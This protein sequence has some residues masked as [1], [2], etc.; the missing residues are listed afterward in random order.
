MNFAS[1]P[2]L[3]PTP[4]APS[5]CPFHA[6]PETLDG[7]LATQT[8]VRAVLASLPTDPSIPLPPGTPTRAELTAQLAAIATGICALTA[9]PAA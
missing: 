8:K 6:G 9:A 3:Q 2:V 7:L 4:T 1:S 5:R